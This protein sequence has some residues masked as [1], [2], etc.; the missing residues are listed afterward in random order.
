MPRLGFTVSV[1]LLDTVYIAWCNTIL[2][3]LQGYMVGNGVTDDQV[4]GDAIIPF[5]YGMGLISMDMYKVS[6]VSFWE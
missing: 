6:L 4:D 3:A 1:S 5:V 2:L